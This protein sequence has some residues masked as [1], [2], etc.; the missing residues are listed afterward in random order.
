MN[1]EEDSP[2]AVGKNWVLLNGNRTVITVLIGISI[3]IVLCGLW[4]GGIIAFEN[5]SAVTRLST[6]IVAGEFS[7]LTIVLSIN[8]LILSQETGPAG[9]I[10]ERLDGMI[11]FRHRYERATGVDVTPAE[12]VEMMDTLTKSTLDEIDRLDAANE[13][14]GDSALE[15][16]ISTYCTLTKR[17]ITDLHE[18]LSCSEPGAFNA[19][20]NAIAKNYGWQAHIARKLR[21]EGGDRLSGES[22]DALTSIINLMEVFSIAR[23][24]FKTIYIRRELGGVSREFLIVG[25]P[26]VLS[27]FVLN[28]I[29]GGLT[30]ALIPVPL[31]SPVAIVLITI[32]CLPI[33]LLASYILRTATVARRTANIGPMAL[34]KKP[35]IES[36]N[37]DRSKR[38]ET[39]TDSK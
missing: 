10:Q 11:D 28:S 5:S 2:F 33:A 36:E 21:A 27:G 35:R 15:N 24:H 16:H 13:G 17:N 32:G 4:L 22:H 20:S 30:G 9:Q 7:L 37:G 34:E 23:T 6:G 8:Q 39:K 14:T 18:S 12:P 19:L 29:Y 38:M 25:I 26:G 3:F 31:L 1:Q